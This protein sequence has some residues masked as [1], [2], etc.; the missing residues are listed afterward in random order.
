MQQAHNDFSGFYRHVFLPEHQEPL[1]IALH[2]FGTLASALFVIVMFIVGTPWLALLYP[3]IHAAPGLLGHR[4]FERSAEVGD[5]RVTR[6]DYSPL[7]FIAGNHRMSW[8][9]ICRGF[10]WRVS[11]KSEKSARL[12][13]RGFVK[14]TKADQRYFVA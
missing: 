11:E 4:Y 1:N 5:L 14:R 8:E 9:L 10:Y 6:K 2:V 12:K 13:S 3:V 7:W